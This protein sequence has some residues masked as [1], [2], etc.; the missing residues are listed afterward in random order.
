MPLCLSR[1]AL[2]PHRLTHPSIHATTANL[3]LGIKSA[4]E[5]DPYS[6]HAHAHHTHAHLPA[7][8]ELIP[9]IPL[10]PSHPPPTDAGRW[11]DTG[12]WSMLLSQVERRP[13]NEHL[14][15]GCRPHAASHTSHFPYPRAAIHSHFLRLTSLRFASSRPISTDP[16]LTGPL[17]CTSYL[18]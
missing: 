18:P 1:T 13:T 8:S 16:V 17:H 11:L 12:H 4:G 6:V 7:E 10:K 2:H 15:A 3:R 5:E 9:L 14:L